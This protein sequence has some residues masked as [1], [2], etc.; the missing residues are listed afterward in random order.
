MLYGTRCWRHRHLHSTQL[1]VHGAGMAQPEALAE[2][3]S[4]VRPVREFASVQ[5]AVRQ[6]P[7]ASWSSPGRS[8]CC[9]TDLTLTASCSLSGVNWLTC[10]LA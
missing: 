5:V 7:R 1:W 2:L 8:S 9:V 4:L 6:L 3:L 10:I